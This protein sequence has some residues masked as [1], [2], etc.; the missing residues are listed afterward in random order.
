MTVSDDERISFFSRKVKEMLKDNV[1]QIILF[2]SHARGDFHDGSD[3]DFVIIVKQHNKNVR[4]QISK[5]GVEF[6]N[7]YDQLAASLVYN[8]QEWA[9][10]Q[11]FPIGT[12]IQ[13]E[14]ISL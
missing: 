1:I 3:Y 5:I 13:R 2:G 10:T 7:H 9:D 12:N 6:L 14:G 11:L 8:E 4:K